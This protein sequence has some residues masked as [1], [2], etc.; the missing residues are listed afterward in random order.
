[1]AIYQRRLDETDFE[2]E[3]HLLLGLMQQRQG[4]ADAAARAWKNV[5]EARQVSPKTLEELCSPVC[6]GASLGGG[7]SGRRTA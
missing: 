6:P 4:H 5:L 2:A 3:D 1:M 7:D